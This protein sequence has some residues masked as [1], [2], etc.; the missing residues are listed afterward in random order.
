MLM[1]R[2]GLL[3]MLYAWMMMKPTRAAVYLKENRFDFGR[4][5]SSLRGFRGRIQ[6]C[7]RARLCL[8]GNSGLIGWHTTFYN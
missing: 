8:G 3:H 4:V 7:V 5:L 6:S 2:Q 1:Y